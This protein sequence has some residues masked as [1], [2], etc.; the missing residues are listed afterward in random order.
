MYHVVTLGIEMIFVIAAAFSCLETLAKKCVY[1]FQER[2]VP[3]DP[4]STKDKEETLQ[5]LNQIIE[6]RLVTSELPLHMRNLKIRKFSQTSFPDFIWT[7]TDQTLMF[8][9]QRMG[10]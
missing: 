10:G 2:I 9:L 8:L 1:L 4:I 7:I 5:R 3:P 6:Y